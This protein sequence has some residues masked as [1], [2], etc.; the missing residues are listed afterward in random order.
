MSR[1]DYDLFTIGAGS[2][3]VRASR[4]AAAS[5]GRVAIAEE[6]YLGG[7]CVNAGCVPKKLLMYASQFASSFEDAAGF[8]WSV[9][10]L[11]FEWAALIANKDR[12]IGR[13]NG[14]YRRML[15]TSGATVIDARA[16]LVDGHTVAVDGRR[17]TAETIL[18]ATGGRPFV[19]DVP[20]ADLAI[21]SDEAFHLEQLPE[22]VV[23]VGG[24]Y[25]AVEF[26]GIFDGLGCE[27]SLL[28][29]GELFLRGFD[30]DIRRTLADVMAGRGV[31]LHFDTE[32]AG[33]ESCN[34]GLRLVTTTGDTHRADVVLWAIGRV[35]NTSGL[36]LDRVG[37]DL[38]DRGAIQVD[39]YSRSSVPSIYAVGDVTDRRA[40]TPVAI[41]EGAAFAE[42]VFNDNPTAVEY[43]N[44]P[45]AVFSQPPV[46]AVGLTEAEARDAGHDVVVFRSTFRPML[47]TLSG[48]DE[49]T[50]MKLVVDRP[51]DAVLGIHM[52][53][54]EAGEIIQGFAVALKAGA[55][56]AVFDST[57]GI[58]PTAAEEFVTMREPVVD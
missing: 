39:R 7:T 21:T 57:V 34:R 29:R 4:M 49:H 56:K 58:H 14:A 27:V 32:V 17:F 54:P 19:P 38:T 48:R 13:L 36:E 53:G 30:D 23:V 2:G 43:A 45:T 44:I 22:R 6:R 25:V 9:G 40:L 3:G 8:G 18:V 26:A 51:S 41:A 10:G 15:E 12:E 16:T 55:T 42:T 11:D 33:I 5:G 1:F 37:V 31:D 20:G 35:P 52:V 46:G 28:Y 50:M 24:G 47:N